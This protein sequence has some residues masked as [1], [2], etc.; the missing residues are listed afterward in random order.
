MKQGFTYPHTINYELQ[1]LLEPRATEKQATE[2][3][4]SQIYHFVV[5][6]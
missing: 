2:A 6:A 1:D 4:A 5:V 3:I